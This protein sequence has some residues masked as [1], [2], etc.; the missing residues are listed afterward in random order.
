VKTDVEELTPTR[1][2][3]TIEVPF[4]ELKPNLDKAY[5][6][7]SKQVRLKGFRPGKV[8][9]PLIDR[10]VGRG[11]VLQEAV[12][13]ALPDLYGKAVQETKVFALGT[14]EVDISK[15]DDGAELVFTAE[16]DIRPSFEVPD[17]DGLAVT[18]DDATVT[19]D[20]VEESLGSLRER[21][22][23]LKNADRPA[24]S[25]DFVS[26][27]LAATVDG[28]DIEDARTSGYSYQVGDGA[29]IEGLD[30]ALAG[31]SSGDT[32]TFTSKLV[33]GDRAGE[34]AEITVTVHSVKIKEL[35][36]MDDDFAQ[37]ASEFDTIGELRADTRAGLERGKRNQQF[38]Q[39]R[40]RALDALMDKIDIPLPESAV[41]QEVDRR[42]EQL[43]N[44][45]QMF[46]MSR[47]QYLSGQ[48]KTEEEFDLEI[49]QGA[50]HGVK[51]GFI[52]DQLALQEELEA[53]NEELTDF[54]VQQAMQMGVQP[55][56]LA[57]HLT[58]S[59]QIPALVTD[60]LRNKALSL[61]VEHVKVTDES[62]N[63]VDLKAIQGEAMG[64]TVDAEGANADSAAAEG[65]GSTGK[66]DADS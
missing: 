53:Q 63:E 65:A 55:D 43:D 24:E 61:L 5:K 15:L 11:A 47:E 56:Q 60:V 49:E 57:K 37:M 7:I 18:V 20:Q 45:L 30:D 19:P 22:S 34:E 2:K 25:G 51:G 38:S 44:Q 59:G 62:G 64:D 42:K 52:L 6:E 8:P 40:D 33:G 41:Q 32:K 26:I 14:P 1:V 39:A 21:F 35:P 46:G 27:D 28:E 17:Y 4:E 36:E 29:A 50:R 23:T 58:E 66:A 48:G 16:V 12:N 9:A 13:D 54:V 10:Y 3:L 31:M